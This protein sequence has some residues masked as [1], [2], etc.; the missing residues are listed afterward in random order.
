MTVSF[1]A[2][3]SQNGK[4]FVMHCKIKRIETIWWINTLQT[5]KKDILFP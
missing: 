2:T 5:M 4:T 1:V 3:F